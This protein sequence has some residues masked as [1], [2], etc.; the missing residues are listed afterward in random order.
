[1]EYSVNNTIILKNVNTM[2]KIPYLSPQ[3]TEIGRL[4][5]LRAETNGFKSSLIRE[6]ASSPL[7]KSLRMAG[8]ISEALSLV[9]SPRAGTTSCPS[10]RMLQ[11][12]HGD[13]WVEEVPAIARIPC[14]PA[15][16]P[17]KYNPCGHRVVPHET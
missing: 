16:W 14:P 13:E 17:V 15:I 5:L 6:L 10:F 11:P 9:S 1:M 4:E 8:N 3:S 2:V 12:L 7:N